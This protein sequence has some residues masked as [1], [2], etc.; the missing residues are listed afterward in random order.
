LKIVCGTLLVLIVVILVALPA[1]IGI[2]PIIGPKSR[3]LTDR[4]FEATRERL[5]RGEYLV[6]RVD[7]CLFCHSQRDWDAPGFPPKAGTEGGGSNLAAEGMPWLSA[8]NITPDPETG[9]GTWTDDM[10][11]RAI[12]EGIGHDGRAL[13]PMMPYQQ[14]RYM[15]DED[16]ASVVT[17]IRSLKPLRTQVPP[18]AIPFPVNRFINAVP[19]PVTAPV[20]EPDRTN[21]VAY[22]GYLVRLGVCRDCHNTMDAQGQQMPGMEFAGGT[23]LPNPGGVVASTNI[24]PSPSGIPYYTEDL[25]LELMRTGRVKARKIHDMMP[26]AGYGKQTD[27]DLKA[28]F[29]YLKTVTPVDHRVDNSLAPTDCPRCGLTHGGGELNQVATK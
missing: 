26:W 5:E 7:G 16:L 2:R 29:A 1:V 6:N 28:I 17:Y 25:F 27:E 12:R 13:F 24:T 11:A 19:E 18:S 20:A 15:S 22:G 9:A 23:T 8:P 4:R 10:L 14:Y 21:R 3:P